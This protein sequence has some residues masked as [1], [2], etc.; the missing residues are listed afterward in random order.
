M[1]ALKH[2]QNISTYIFCISSSIYS[3]GHF[4]EHTVTRLMSAAPCLQLHHL[5]TGSMTLS[6]DGS[7]CDTSLFC[8]PH[9]CQTSSIAQDPQSPAPDSITCTVHCFCHNL[10]K[11]PVLTSSTCSPKGDTLGCA[12]WSPLSGR[13]PGPNPAS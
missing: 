12:A 11:L 5:T 13:H 6:V 7:N 8:S 2:K 3:H 9:H 4:G 1:Q 10:H